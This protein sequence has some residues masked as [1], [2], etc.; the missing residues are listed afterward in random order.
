[1]DTTYLT[2]TVITQDISILIAIGVLLSNP[3]KARKEYILLGIALSTSFMTDAL[4]AVRYWVFHLSSNSL[5][6]IGSLLASALYLLFYRSQ[7]KSKGIQS[8]VAAII[9]F[10][11]GS[12]AVNMS[13]IQG[14]SSTT[15]YSYAIR[16]IAFLVVSLIYFNFLLRKNPLETRITTLPMFWIN[17][18]FLIYYAG[19]FFQWLMIDYILNVLKGDVINTYMIKNGLGIIHYL[20]IAYGLWLNRDSYSL[21]S[22]AG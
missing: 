5:V 8:I 19:V 7:F 17:S 1:M 11:V 20:M 15:S 16:S 13:F 10:D 3:E 6:N 22:Q 4:A 2:A 18:S 21:N 14:V 12:V 9:L